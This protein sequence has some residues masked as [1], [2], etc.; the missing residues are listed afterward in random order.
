MEQQVSTPWTLRDEFVDSRG[1]LLA[2]LFYYV[3]SVNIPM[4]EY[5]K[6]SKLLV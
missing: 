5:V 2:G 3:N 6:M 4:E 1:G